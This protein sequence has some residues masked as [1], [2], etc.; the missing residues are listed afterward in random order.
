MQID[1]P[2]LCRVLFIVGVLLCP[3]AGSVLGETTSDLSKQE[4][5][6]PVKMAVTRHSQLR[7]VHHFNRDGRLTEVELFPTQETDSVQYRLSYDDAGR[8]TEE[9]TIKPDGHVLYQKYYRYGFDGQG[10]QVAMLAATDDGQ[11]AYAEFNLYDEQGALT[12]DLAITG[13]GT[14]EKS[15]YDIGGKLI[16]LARYFHGRLVLESTHHHGALDRLEESRFYSGNGTLMR[17]DAYRY[18]AAGLRI[19]QQ[20]EFFRSAHLRK[21]RVTYEFDTVGNWTKETIQRWT[22]KHGALSLM[23]TVVSR[24]RQITYH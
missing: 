2:W 14:V 16:Y 9:Q 22:E 15:L 20:S 3:A 6:G 17:K 4:L 11:L 21:S 23:E 7:T 24:E 5:T 10:R 18:N 13:N 19:E 12:E 8:V 1:H